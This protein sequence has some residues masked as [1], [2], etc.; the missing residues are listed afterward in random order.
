MPIVETLNSRRLRSSSESFY[1]LFSGFNSRGADRMIF[2]SI[3][4][5]VSRIIVSFG[6]YF[7]QTA[8]N[9]IARLI[10]IV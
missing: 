5:H 9:Y 10:S 4:Q 1:R 7:V 8:Q 2:R 3:E 6:G